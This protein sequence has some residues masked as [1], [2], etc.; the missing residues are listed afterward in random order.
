MWECGRRCAFPELDSGCLR[1]QR[2]KLFH[3]RGAGSAAW[4]APAG[5]LSGSGS[6]CRTER[7]TRA[8]RGS[9]AHQRLSPQHA[10][11][12]TCV[13]G[14]RRVRAE[15]PG[16]STVRRRMTV[17]RGGDAAAPGARPPARV[18]SSFAPLSRGHA[19]EW[20][21]VM[22]VVTAAIHYYSTSDWRSRDAVH[23]ARLL[24]GNFCP[25]RAAPASGAA[26]FGRNARPDRARAP[27]RRLTGRMNTEC[28]KSPMSAASRT[29]GL[30]AAR[31]H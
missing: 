31:E 24:P 1:P 5:A 9:Q 8:S 16:W 28:S 23:G 12:R 3:R 4:A 7:A 13:W 14:G 26:K 29:R 21:N 10:R 20:E 25:R 19:P 6:C 30:P 22:Y 2:A 11:R 15:A 17:V 18:S 27:A